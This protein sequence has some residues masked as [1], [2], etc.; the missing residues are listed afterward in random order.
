VLFSS[1]CFSILL[2]ISPFI[3]GREL[4]IR[5]RIAGRKVKLNENIKAI[6]AQEAIEIEYALICIGD[7]INKTIVM[8]AIRQR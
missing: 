6:S 5:R 4:P 2:R 8:L 7:R 1:S 3:K